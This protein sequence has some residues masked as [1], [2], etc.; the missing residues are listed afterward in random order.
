MVIS[1]ALWQRRFGGRAD[2]VNSKVIL[3]GA[4]ETVVGIMPPG[5]TYPNNTEMW[6]PLRFDPA[7]EP[8]DNRYLRA[9]A[10]LKPNVSMAQAQAE[11]NTISE[12][13]APGLRGH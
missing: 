7:K 2:V 9:V 13:L 5:F 11:M 1:H 12:R 3:D 4:P 8:R 6:W 10:R